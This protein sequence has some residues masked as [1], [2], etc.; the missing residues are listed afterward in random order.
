MA[1]V[2]T[3]LYIWVIDLLIKRP[4]TFAEIRKEYTKRSDYEIGRDL[5]EKTFY[6]WRNKISS[7]FKVEIEYRNGKYCITNPEKVYSNK[8][9][10]WLIQSMTVSDVVSKSKDLS[11]R[12]LLEEVPSSRDYLQPLIEAM[13]DNRM[14]KMQYHR[15]GGTTYEFEA[16]PLCLKVN[17]RRWYVLCRLPQGKPNMLDYPEYAYIGNLRIYALDRIDSL[18]ILDQHFEYP[19]DFDPEEFFKNHYGVCIA[20][21]QPLQHVVLAVSKQQRDYI[22]SLPLHHSQKRIEDYEEYSIYELEIHP[23]I[24]FIRALMSFGADIEVLEPPY[25]RE[26]LFN[27]ACYLRDMYEEKQS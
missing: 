18:E 3:E 15:F 20:Y 25:L 4:K 22:D 9:L 14:V 11:N 13:K 26:I 19:E 2:N 17:N 6:N 7:L 24:D 8:A 27:E 23:T 10:Q 16:E 12:I 21:N 5:Q 1:K